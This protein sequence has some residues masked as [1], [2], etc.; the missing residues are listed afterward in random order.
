M[1]DPRSRLLHLLR[2]IVSLGM[3][4]M[5]A[6]PAFSHADSDAMVKIELTDDTLT[7]TWEAAVRDFDEALGLDTDED[8]RLTREEW[9]AGRPAATSYF[10]ARLN[11]ILD[12]QLMRFRSGEWELAETAQGT[13]ARIRFTAPCPSPAMP[14]LIE[15]QA[16]FDVD[17]WHR[18]HL[19][20]TRADGV[21]SS[22]ILGP[23]K[24]RWR[25]AHEPLTGGTGTD[26]N[27]RLY[28]PLGCAAAVA[29]VGMLIIGCSR[30]LWQGRLRGVAPG[31][32]GRG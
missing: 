26:W 17:P 32:S 12:G 25:L 30:R 22:A 5:V 8:G 16:F 29:F 3:G 6:G 24:P 15:Y 7:G 19:T 4:G 11:L 1:T 13:V 27:L 21:S 31:G 10:H 9:E 20:F 18:A 28:P 23:E 2:V 14:A